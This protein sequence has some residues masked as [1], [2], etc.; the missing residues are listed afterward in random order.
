M[1]N[2][3]GF[4]HVGLLLTAPS[5]RLVRIALARRVPR[6]FLALVALAGS[7]LGCTPSIGDK[8]QVS[9]DCS[10]RGDRL[11]DLSQPEGYCTQLNCIG[12]SCADEASCVLFDRA[13]PGCRADDRDGLTG[14]RVAR[15]FCMAKCES[16]SDC[17]PGYECADPT[18]E[19]W[20]ATILDNDQ[21]KRSCLIRSLPSGESDAGYSPMPSSKAVCEATAPPVSAIDASAPSI[22]PP[23]GAPPAPDAGTVSDAGVADASDG[24]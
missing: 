10:I 20:N 11:C 15:S 19:P 13:V 22:Q 5:H 4:R 17:R 18:T 8:C 2:C 23:N 6:A 12:Q 3:I 7:A 24:G 21:K 9:T 1:S 14:S 16:N